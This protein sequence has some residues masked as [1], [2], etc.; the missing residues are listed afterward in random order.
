MKSYFCDIWN[1]PICFWFLYI[2]CKSEYLNN[3]T[4]SQIPTIYLALQMARKI[5]TTSLA[6]WKN[7]LVSEIVEYFDQGGGDGGETP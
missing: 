4:Q 7:Y 1:A 6:L 5:L 3:V 2:Y